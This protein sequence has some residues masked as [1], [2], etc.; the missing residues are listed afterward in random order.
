MIF[1]DMLIISV[2]EGCFRLGLDHLILILD[3]IPDYLISLFAW[4]D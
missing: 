3:L 4:M 1:V 2:V